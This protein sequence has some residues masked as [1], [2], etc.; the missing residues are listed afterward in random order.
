[1]PPGPY[2]LTVVQWLDADA[3]PTIALR[4]EALQ[5]PMTSSRIVLADAE[6][7]PPEPLLELGE[8]GM[9]S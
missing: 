1:M 6:L 7:R 4:F 2:R 8:G 5:A 3:G 9:Q